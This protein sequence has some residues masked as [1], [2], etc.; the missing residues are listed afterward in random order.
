MNPNM[1]KRD[2]PTG[3]SYGFILNNIKLFNKFERMS[4]MLGKFYATQALRPI[5]RYHTYYS[6]Y[7]TE[8]DYT[9][10]TR[11]LFPTEHW[12]EPL[13]FVNGFGKDHHSGV[14]KGYT[15]SLA[16]S[17]RETIRLYRRC[18]LPK[19]LW[20]PPHLRP[21]AADWDAFGLEVIV[22]IDNA[23]DL[24]SYGASL[25]FLVNGTV[26]LRMPARKG[27][28]KG[29]IERGNLTVEQMHISSRSGYVPS[30]F[31]GLDPRYKAQRMKAKLSADATVAQ[32]EDELVPFLMEYNDMP[33]PTLKK[34][35]CLVHRD[36]QELAPLILPCGLT[37]LRTTF[38]LTF[39][40]KLLREGV[41]CDGLKF[42]SK[43]LGE[44]FHNYTGYVIVK[45]DPDD[46]R[47]VLVLIPG[48]DDPVEA[49]LT[50]FDFDFPISLELVKVLL[51]RIAAK[52]PDDETWMQDVNY[53][54]HAELDRLQSKPPS[55]T[56]GR[57]VATDAQAASHAAAAPPAPVPA[58]R[59]LP[60]LE[61][62]L[63]GSELP[64]E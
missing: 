18:V 39:R 43:A 52:H 35:R 16:P 12:N 4:E 28:L 36:S 41:E 50:T 15:F 42:N 8:L 14:F 2:A 55:R 58:P 9:R 11:F 47:T 56:P 48:F 63:R 40:V 24:T 64:D 32:A 30:M 23:S 1:A 27:D 54:V 25:M 38:A 20:L 53:E 46:I 21:Y 29:G 7:R 10:F 31:S 6:G 22:A 61:E 49:S 45:M 37:Q 3:V 57:T 60:S 13:P 17:T 62:L 44:A 19:S 59:T 26:I 33:H 34:R 51:D 5:G